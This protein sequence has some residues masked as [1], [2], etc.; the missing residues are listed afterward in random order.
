M[1]LEGSNTIEFDTGLGTFVSV[2]PGAIPWPSGP[3]TP[4]AL[5]DTIDQFA[6][7]HEISAVALDGSRDRGS[8]LRSTVGD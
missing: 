3:L 6:R 8:N 7:N 1:V 2:V 5:A 4:D